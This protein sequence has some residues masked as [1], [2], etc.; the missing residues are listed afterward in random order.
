VYNVP[1]FANANF[2][3]AK[4]D[5][6]NAIAV[7]LNKNG[8]NLYPN[9]VNNN[10]VYVQFNNVSKGKYMIQLG[11]MEGKSLV[12]KSVNIA[13]A[14]SHTESLSASGMASGV[15]VVRV[16]NDKGENMYKGNVIIS[17]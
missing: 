3:F 5:K 2:A 7:T 14:G 10:M 9:P 6:A 13:I 17:R 16:V 1:D 12:Q 4:Q 15:Y 8:I 11:D